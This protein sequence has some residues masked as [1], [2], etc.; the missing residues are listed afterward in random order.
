VFHDLP[1]EV[2]IGDLADA[3]QVADAAEG[4]KV[5]YHLGAAK[6]GP[7][8]EHVR[9]TIRGTANV[10]RA[11]LLQ[12]GTRLVHVSSIAVYGKPFRPQHPLTEDT[13]YAE[14]PMTAYA[15]AKIEAERIVQ[16]A[17]ARQALA[18]TILR[19]GIVYGPGSP[20]NLSKIGC[21]VG[22]I[23]FVVGRRE[24]TLPLVYVGN[25]VDALLLAGRSARGVGKAYHVVDDGCPTKAGYIRL[26]NLAGPLR[27]ASVV[28]P[29]PL[30]A[31]IG[32]TARRLGRCHRALAGIGATLSPLH[33]RSC[34]TELAFDTSRIKR[35]LGWQPDPRIEE[36]VRRTCEAAAA[37]G[38]PPSY[39]FSP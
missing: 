15:R 3:A 14:G 23:F 24:I 37:S 2:V 29:Y 11:A 28:L 18:A 21:Q 38:Q 16:D 33:L 26:L 39:A 13:P 5:I 17:A 34:A 36:H 6:E 12:P 25:L 27:Y 8:E 30:A 9:G 1:L 19:P 7:W 35:E 22:R 31:V 32:W 10:V 20:V 4:V